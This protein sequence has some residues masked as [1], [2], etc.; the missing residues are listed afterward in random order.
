MAEL[1]KSFENESMQLSLGSFEVYFKR[2]FCY[3][4]VYYFVEILEVATCTAYTFIELTFAR[5]I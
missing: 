2:T 4:H 3:K 1:S 5:T